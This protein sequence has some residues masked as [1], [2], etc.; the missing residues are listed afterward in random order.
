M[1][2]KESILKREALSSTSFSNACAIP[3]PIQMLTEESFCA[4]L[5]L[6]KP[7]RWGEKWVRFVFLL[8]PSKYHPEDLRRFNDHLAKLFLNAKKLE[9]FANDPTYLTL[10]KLL[11]EG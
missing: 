6:N 10:K 7:M 9:T 3:H 11:V 8:S 1:E 5:V 2:L 4:V